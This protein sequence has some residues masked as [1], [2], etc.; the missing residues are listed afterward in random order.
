MS[1]EFTWI[2]AYV[3]VE[4]TWTGRDFD[5]GGGG[6]SRRTNSNF[7]DHPPVPP[8]GPTT[9]AQMA[10]A[11][12]GQLSQADMASLMGGGGGVA[13]AQAIAQAM[14]AAGMGGASLAGLMGGQQL[15]PGMLNSILPILQ[16]PPEVRAE[17]H[18]AKT[19]MG[20]LIGRGGSTIGHI[21]Q[22]SAATIKARRRGMGWSFFIYKESS[23]I[24]TYR[25]T[26]VHAYIRT[27]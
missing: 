11:A 20:A 1:V 17:M 9:N 18:L 2:D 15:T 8:V 22:M 27:Y 7:S 10:A 13:Q 6:S 24:P 21:R 3:S 14:A 16:Q 23:C 25:H 5:G 19:H 26:S 12:A 4:C